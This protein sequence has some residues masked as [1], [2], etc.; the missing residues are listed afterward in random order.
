MSVLSG[1]AGD[2]EEFVWK[3]SVKPEN[4]NRV[5]VGY[6]NSKWDAKETKDNTFFATPENFIYEWT[7]TYKEKLAKDETAKLFDAVKLSSKVEHISDFD[8]NLIAEAVQADGFDTAEAAFAA[9][10]DAE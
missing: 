7:F 2:D 6:D 5:F 1:M 10:F 3:T 4:F 9:T 8:I